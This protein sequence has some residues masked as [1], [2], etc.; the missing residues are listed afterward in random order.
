MRWAALYR[1]PPILRGVS[2]SQIRADHAANQARINARYGPALPSSPQLR[3]EADAAHHSAVI[4]HARASGACAGGC[5][6]RLALEIESAGWSTNCTARDTQAYPRD[7]HCQSALGSAADHGE[8][9]KLGVDIRQT[10]VAKYMTRRRDPPSQGWRTFL[11]NHA[12]GIAAMDMF[13]VPTFSFRLLYG[14]L[15]MG[16]GRRHILWFGVT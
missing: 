14:L 1:R 11:R 7:E 15:I 13:R 10:S 16:H 4:S 6:A 2:A 5:S 3:G 9:L 12:D 8:L